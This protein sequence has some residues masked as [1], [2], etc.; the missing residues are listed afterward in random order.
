MKASELIEKLN[1][2]IK[3]HGDCNVYYYDREQL[4]GFDSADIIKQKTYGFGNKTKI[5]YIE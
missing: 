3:E 5:F 4:T 2:L 1:E